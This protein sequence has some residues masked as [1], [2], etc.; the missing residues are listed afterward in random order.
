MSDDR[1]RHDREAVLLYDEANSFLHSKLG[2]R[3]WEEIKVEIEALVEELKTADAT[4]VKMI[5]TI[6]DNI[7]LRERFLSFVNTKIQEGEA[8]LEAYAAADSQPQGGF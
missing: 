4:D 5:Q 7:W 2:R 1:Y 6:Q 8:V 3:L